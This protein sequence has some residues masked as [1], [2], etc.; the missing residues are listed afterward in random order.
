MKTRWLSMRCRLYRRGR[1][2][3]VVATGMPWMTAQDA[4]CGEIAAAHDTVMFECF[5]GVTG[6]AR[7]EATIRPEQ[8]TDEVLVQA[9]QSLQDSAHCFTTVRQCRSRLRV[10]AALSAS[11]AP[12][13][14]LTTRSTA[15]NSC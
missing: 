13:R 5:F 1:R 3:R 2:H 14:A 12:E 6:A 9:N 4:T 11:R 10:I 7:I 15:G 8:R